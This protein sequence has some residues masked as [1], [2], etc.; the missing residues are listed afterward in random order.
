MINLGA[1]ASRGLDAVYGAQQLTLLRSLSYTVDSAGAAT[2]QYD[3]PTTV[4][5]RV[6]SL[7]TDALQHMDNL[8]IQG[9][10]RR[11]YLRG[12][13]AAA[14]RQDGGGGDRLQFPEYPGGPVRT[15]LVVMV[16]EQWPDRNV[17]TVRLQN[18]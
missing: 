3:V 10:L 2:P 8:N 12:V 1:I 14:S 11:V 5:A 17:V 15:W 13:V 7:S 18:S 9:T 6:E 4:W 16:N